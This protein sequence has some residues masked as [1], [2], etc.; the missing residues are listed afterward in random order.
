MKGFFCELLFLCSG[1][2]PAA[3]P[4]PDL[5]YREVLFHHY[6]DDHETALVHTLVADTQDRFGED[7][8][9]FRL[10]EGSFAFS[11]R[12]FSYAEQRF[13]AVADEELTELEQMRLAFHLSREFYRRGDWASLEG[14]LERIDLG[15]TW[16]G[17]SKHHPEVAFMRAQLALAR[18]D[19][20][21]SSAA[22]ANIEPRNPL[23]AY[24]LYNLGVAQRQAGD[25]VSA[26]ETFATLSSMK[27]TSEDAFD[28][29]QR[30]RLALAYLRRDLGEATDAEALLTALPSD[31][32]Y[33]DQALASY[34]QLAMDTE[35]Y[36]LAARV[37]LTL[38]EQDYWTPSTASARLG[39]PASLEMLA[40]P[41][42]ALTQYKAAEASFERRLATLASLSERSADP[43][44]VSGLLSVF[45]AREL[46]DEQLRD[47]VSRWQSELGHTDWLE[48]LAAEDVHDVLLQ[49]RDLGEMKRYLD[50]LPQDL[51][52]FEE[53]AGE[54]RRRAL[55]ARELVGS[56]GLAATR[57]RLADALAER[58]AVV[59]AT[60]QAAV[61]PTRQWMQ[62]LATDDE[63]ALLDEL[64]RMAEIGALGLPERKK[65][66]WAYR[67]DR[68]R[69][70][71]Y[72]TIVQER[73]ARLR[74]LAKDIA[75]QRAELADIDA[76]IA[77]VNEAE[78][79][80]VGGV[81][82]DYSQFR[83]RAFDIAD[84]V[85]T[86]LTSRQ[87]MLAQQIRRGMRGEQE[88][89]QQYL[90]V[91]RVA[92]ARATDQLAAAAIDGSSAAVTE[93]QP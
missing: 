66:R 83:D 64:D 22:L 5:T 11:E 87:E 92:I 27:A 43:Q 9:R 84:R 58:E 63:L 16:L 71:V 29:L 17:R 56:D 23:Y 26:A 81:V 31:S 30:A 53:L 73:N 19:L 38:Q 34:A 61:E 45:A 8:V 69:G 76:R 35:D 59:T 13:E 36:E 90:L 75:E 12:M 10:A 32:R 14:Q 15:R 80:L 77:R 46:D 93:Q 33:R 42:A 7:P 68:L 89:L 88:R 20:V 91:T 74:V 79:N 21:A 6:Q 62:R 18:G 37:W 82:T 3:A 47:T 86:A 49:W 24:G 44:W 51:D 28:L 39:F 72:W 25:T 67:V 50:A 40:S 85:D 65:E 54:R 41:E 78:T 55:L 52:V 57:D 4:L 48:W 60:R 70:T 2:D 1:L